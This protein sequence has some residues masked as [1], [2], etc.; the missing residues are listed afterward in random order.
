VWMREG[1][2][3]AAVAV[4]ASYLN[5]ARACGVGGGCLY[6]L[7]EQ[8]RHVYSKSRQRDGTEQKQHIVQKKELP[9]GCVVYLAYV[10]CACVAERHLGSESPRSRVF[11]VSLVHTS[12]LLTSS[13]GTSHPSSRCVTPMS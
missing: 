13:G 1:S 4:T 7:V 10:E 8:H 6:A 9:W 2:A 11:G 12:S 5:P 3:R